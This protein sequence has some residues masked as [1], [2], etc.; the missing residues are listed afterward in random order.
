MSGNTNSNLSFQKLADWEVYGT[1]YTD[2]N[3]NIWSIIAQGESESIKEFVES[4]EFLIIAQPVEAEREFPQVNVDESSGK[5]DD[6]PQKTP[7]RQPEEGAIEVPELNVEVELV[8]VNIPQPYRVSFLIDPT[9]GPNK[10][11]SYNF[12]LQNDT[13]ADITY[14]AEFNVK[15]TLKSGA[16]SCSSDGNTNSGSVHCASSASWKLT[17]KNMVAVKNKFSISGDYNLA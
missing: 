12:T 14:S 6:E 5:G 9:L 8:E 10:S 2:T 11:K 17:V 13:Q 16:T 1:R 3:G 4:K 7:D 15:V